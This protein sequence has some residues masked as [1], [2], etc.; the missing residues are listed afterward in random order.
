MNTGSP[1]EATFQVRAL[2][3]FLYLRTIGQP[4]KAPG[5][6]FWMFLNFK[7]TYAD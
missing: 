3:I 7:L 6:T 5:L 2:N 4:G 1:T